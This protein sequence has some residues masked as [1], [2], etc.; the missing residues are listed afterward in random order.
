MTI[1]WTKVSGHQ[2]R[3]GQMSDLVWPDLTWPEKKNQVRLDIWP[4][5]TWPVRS[6]MENFSWRCSPAKD[7]SI[8]KK[9]N[10]PNGRTQR[11]TFHSSSPPLLIHYYHNPTS[12]LPGLVLRGSGGGHM[13]NYE[14]SIDRHTANYEQSTVG[15][16]GV[17][18]TIHQ[19]S[20]RLYPDVVQYGGRS[21]LKIGKLQRGN[22]SS[23]RKAHLLYDWFSTFSKIS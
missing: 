4:D 23:C 17:L 11:L 19:G 12:S 3:S 13:P 20:D 16:L 10:T 14:Q 5:L 2:V 8:L 1:I 22:L 9:E 15:H 7:R 18:R 6:S 21:L